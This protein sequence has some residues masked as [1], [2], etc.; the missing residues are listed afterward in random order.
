MKK[1]IVGVVA[2]IAGLVWITQAA[3]L[4]KGVD[5]TGRTTVTGA[6]LNQLVDNALP[7]TNRG[8]VIVTNATPTVSGSLSYLTNYLWLDISALPY[9]LKSYQTGSW[10]S[11]TVGAGS[12]GSG[13]LEAN[14]V[15]SGKI[16]ANAIW[17][18]NI[19][20]NTITGAKIPAGEITTSKL[21]LLSV[22]ST[23][24]AAD[25]VTTAKILDAN[26]TGAKIAASTIT[27]DKLAAATIG[28]T[29]IAALAITGTNIAAGTISAD[30]LSFSV[31]TSY[32]NGT[33]ASLPSAAG[34]ST[35]TLTFVPTIFQVVLVCT[36]AANGYSVDDE[37][38]I[39]CAVGKYDTAPAGT[40]ALIPLFTVSQN[41]GVITV[42]RSDGNFD[43]IA[44]SAWIMNKSTGVYQAMTTANYNWKVKAIGF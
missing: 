29:N 26:V 4:Q 11:A 25:A 32:T 40:D 31:T 5:M 18:T 14:A 23:I 41:A 24:L 39:H 8:F 15:I 7:A 37:I 22:D 19:N 3:E 17:T 44:V 43:G 1:Y 33:G 38:P 10:V 6:L 28:G 34:S 36:N 13:N 16:A 30:K 21:A 20:D 12:I 35:A 42:V 9:T 27:G 2:G